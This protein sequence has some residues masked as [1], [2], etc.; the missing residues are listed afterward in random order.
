MNFY[1]TKA[2]HI[3]FDSQLPRL[4]KAL[5]EIAAALSHPQPAIKLNTVSDQ[6][7][8]SC[9]FYGSYDPEKYQSYEQIRILNRQVSQAEIA[10][11]KT[12][13][14]EA[15]QLL[16]AYQRADNIRDDAVA[17]QAYAAGFRTAVQMLLAGSTIPRDQGDSRQT[18]E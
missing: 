1:E 7:L 5:E 17:E 6:E 14:P 10:L 11:R 4:T 12:L 16:D 9:L 13:T 2:G 18:T 8:L 15:D 3:F